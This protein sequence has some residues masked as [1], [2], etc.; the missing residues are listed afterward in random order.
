[1]DS[2]P[3]SVGYGWQKGPSNAP[4]VLNTVLGAEMRGFALPPLLASAAGPLCQARCG[5]AGR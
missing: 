2:L 3:I 4:T 5:A 1:M